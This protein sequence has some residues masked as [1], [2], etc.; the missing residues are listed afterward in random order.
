MDD[1]YIGEIR[2]VPWGW[3][4]VGWLI[5]NGQSLQ[6]MQYQAL[7]AVISN[8]FGGDGR[9]TFSVPD[10]RAKAAVC[11]GPG[12]GL[13]NRVLAQSYGTPTVT[14]N[15][16]QV[17][18][19]N[20]TLMAGQNSATPGAYIST[21]ANNTY[22]GHGTVQGDQSYTTQVTPLVPMSSTAVSSVGAGGAHENRQP[23]LVMNYIIC[24]DGEFPVRP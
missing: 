22:I 17:P 20:H 2:I 19:H 12:M 3:A 11:Q 13:T 5:C 18:P 21:P 6:V 4:P 10:L 23:F 9:T 1:A 8:R 15:I 16:N 14:L 7:F 24:Y